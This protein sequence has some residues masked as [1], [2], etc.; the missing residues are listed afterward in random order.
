MVPAD[1]EK[2]SQIPDSRLCRDSLRAADILSSE[3]G[4]RGM[5][6]VGTGGVVRLYL[7]GLTPGWEK[8]SI[9]LASRS[10][11]REFEN[12]GALS[13]AKVA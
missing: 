4:S 3:A 7:R 13:A 8:L 10:G 9:D 6:V 5:R 12:W 2:E 11:R 1:S